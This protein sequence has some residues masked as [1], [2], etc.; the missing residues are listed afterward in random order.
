MGEFASS[1][2]VSKRAGHGTN[3]LRE[4][5]LSSL[6]TSGGV[7]GNET[8]LLVEDD[9]GVRIVIRR[10]LERHG[11]DVMEAANG[12]QALE[13]CEA[14]IDKIDMVLSDVVM[15]CMSGRILLDRLRELPHMPKILMMSGYT[16]DEVERHGAFPDG[17]PF[18]EKP[19][20][21]AAVT[22]K[23]REVLDKAD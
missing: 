12:A 22:R 21:I 9:E 6:P 14:G 17:T 5:S 20:S 15:P 18:I 10:V 1:D 11:F 23:V 7:S 19:F 13:I 4:K 3:V 8:I 16:E 2:E